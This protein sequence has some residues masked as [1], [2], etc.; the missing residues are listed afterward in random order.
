MSCTVGRHKELLSSPNKTG[1]MKPT[2]T[3]NVTISTICGLRP[4]QYF[5]HVL[6][7]LVLTPHCSGRGS[8]SSGFSG[9][10]CKKAGRGRPELQL[11][12]PGLLP[13]AGAQEEMR[14]P[15][16]SVT[17]GF[18][19]CGKRR[20]HCGF[21]MPSVLSSIS[22]SC[23]MLKT[24]PFVL[25]SLSQRLPTLAA[26][27]LKSVLLGMEQSEGC[28]LVAPCRGRALVGTES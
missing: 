28:S 3:F 9:R 13:G 23:L 14:T 16:S 15:D 26:Q 19:P 17:G 5:W 2:P 27:A 11:S 6:A 10:T 4:T 24:L 12:L 18:L 7:N 20:F 21:G 1:P 8:S 22:I 25:H